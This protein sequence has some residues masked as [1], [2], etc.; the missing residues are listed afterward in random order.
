MEYGEKASC[1]RHSAELGERQVRGQ[2]N[3]F[4]THPCTYHDSQFLLIL[5][6]TASWILDYFYQYYMTNNSQTKST[7]YWNR[8]EKSSILSEQTFFG[9]ARQ[10]ISSLDFVRDPSNVYKSSLHIFVMFVICCYICENFLLCR[11]PLNFKKH[12]FIFYR[13]LYNTVLGSSA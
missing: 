1:I 9:Q 4:L 13:L 11:K 7:S 3:H 5:Y 10:K 12:R 8:E 6:E 2:K